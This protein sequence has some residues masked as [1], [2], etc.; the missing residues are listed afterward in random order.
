MLVPIWDHAIVWRVRV[1]SR[2]TLRDF[3]TEN[4]QAEG[5]LSAWFKEVEK[6]TWLCPADVRAR[7][8]SADFVGDRIVFNV[9]GNKYRLIVAVKY[10][11][12]C[13]VF[14]RFIGTH[15]EYD[16]IDASTV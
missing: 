6:A 10:D 15:A 12:V 1:F 16:K 4:P 13:C 8:R 2:G 14:I 3:W 5:P 11:P 7:Y 9:G